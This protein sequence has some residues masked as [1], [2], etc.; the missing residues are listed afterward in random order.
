MLTMQTY[1]KNTQ[2]RQ[3]FNRF[4][5]IFLMF[6]VNPYHLRHLCVIQLIATVNNTQTLRIRF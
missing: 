6:C 5:Q 1:K 2:M 3:I 4:T